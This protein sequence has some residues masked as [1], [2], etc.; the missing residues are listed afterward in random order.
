MSEEQ[1]ERII[2]HFKWIEAELCILIGILL[3]IAAT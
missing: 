2:K 1:V 3:V